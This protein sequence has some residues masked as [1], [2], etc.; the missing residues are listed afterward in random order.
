M[1]LKRLLE[2]IRAPLERLEQRLV[3]STGCT[4]LCVGLGAIGTA[5]SLGGAATTY[6]L[7]HEP[8]ESVG[9]AVVQHLAASNCT[10]INQ[11][12][13]GLSLTRLDS[14]LRNPARERSSGHTGDD[15]TSFGVINLDSGALEDLHSPRWPRNAVLEQLQRLPLAAATPAAQAGPAASEREHSL[16]QL[17]CARF[18]FELSP[19]RVRVYRIAAPPPTAGGTEGHGIHAG[20]AGG[21]ADAN[22]WLAF[23]YGPWSDGGDRRV[24]FALVDLGNL[25]EAVS[26]HDA[27]L[28]TFLHQSHSQLSSQISLH[29][30]SILR[31]HQ[32]LMQAL[33]A[34]NREDEKLATLRILPFSNQLIVVQ[35]SVDHHELSRSSYLAASGVFLMGLLGTAMVVLVSRSSQLKQ[36]RLNEALARESRT[37]GLT[38]VANRRAWDEALAQAERLRQRHGETYG[39]IVVDLDDFKRIN[40]VHGHQQGD[41]VLAGTARVLAAALRGSDLLARVGGDEFA[42]LLPRPESAGLETLLT[43]LQRGL[44]DV[45]I[46]ASLGAAI[47]GPDQTLEQTWHR[48]DASMFSHKRR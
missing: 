5:I 35:L 31:S 18:H 26:G 22:D 17:S 33:P 36:R 38:Q 30:P 23:L 43:R 40:D 48:A 16:E 21:G 42:I 32:T 28:D 7:L 14:V 39:V 20:H 8:M 24:S 9:G 27:G 29:P 6:W 15:W 2:R 46:H 1:T 12:L 41:A 3:R 44:R 34:L 11:V 19:E 47:C 10:A 37:D 45:G 25:A 4:R 13:A